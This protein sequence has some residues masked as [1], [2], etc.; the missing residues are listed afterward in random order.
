MATDA[1]PPPT[2]PPA[3]PPEPT[4]PAPGGPPPPGPTTEPTPAQPDQAPEPEPSSS[5]P[6]QPTA[7]VVLLAIGSRDANPDDDLVWNHLDLV[8]ADNSE[9]AKR[10]A[11]TPAHERVIRGE[12]RKLGDEELAEGE[13]LWL[14]TVPA[15]SWKPKAAGVAP[16]PPPRIE[17]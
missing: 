4:P 1:P 16:P 15:R 14:A 7:Y 2:T 3:P 12:T 10:A 6:H 9:D 13:T 11:L 5:R 8:T 17:V